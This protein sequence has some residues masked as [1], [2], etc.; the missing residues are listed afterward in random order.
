AH[1]R[2]VEDLRVSEERY[3][4][5][6]RGSNDGLWDWDLVANEVHWSLRWATMLG[7]A[8]REIGTS[9]DEWLTRV[10]QDDIGR[11]KEML[12]VHLA[13]GNGQFESEHRIR[14]RSGT[15]RWVLCRGAAVRDSS[16]NATRLVGSLTDVTDA[17][18]SDALTGLPNRLLFVDV[19]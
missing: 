16:G 7:Y 4:L 11:V 3:A 9:P 18:I 1:K 17:K 14:H 5:A 19:L 8:E 13:N 2:A 15:F 6:M 12:A 10:H